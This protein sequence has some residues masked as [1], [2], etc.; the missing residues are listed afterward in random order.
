[1][2]TMTDTLAT[3][4]LQGGEWLLKPT[5]PA[6]V[7]TPER[8]TEEHRLIAQT[9]TDFVNQEVLP[10]LDRLEAKDWELSRQLLRRAGELGLTGVDVAETYGGLQLDKATSL[11]V[12]ERIAL[13]A[14]FSATFGAH[15]NLAVL[16]LSVFGT[17]AQKQKYLSKL[18]TGE[19]VGAYCLS[20]SQ[21]G[22]DALGAKARAVKQ[23]DGSFLLNGEK[24]WITNGGFADLFIVFAKVLD[25]AGEHFSA[26]IVER[27][28]GGVSSGKKSTR[29][30]CTGHRPRR[31]CL[32]TCACRLITCWA[33]SARV[34][35]SRSTC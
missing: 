16:P 28:F 11:V 2:A 27:A 17:E 18:L 34:T 13:S 29:W 21:S 8:M 14:S 5:N 25:D 32:R 22:S 23:P 20:E 31:C 33:R 15:T 24:M 4:R 30:G 35:R 6:G 10:A 12:A 7:F 9:V 1:M 19:S 26:F 3:S